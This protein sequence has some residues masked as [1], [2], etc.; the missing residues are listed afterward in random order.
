M[1]E[2]NITN[3]IMFSFHHSIRS[4]FSYIV[5]YASKQSKALPA[6]GLGYVLV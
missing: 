2:A 1:V 6:L 4:V 5:F 3:I